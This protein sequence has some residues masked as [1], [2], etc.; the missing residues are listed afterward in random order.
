MKIG[1]IGVGAMG[2]PIAKLL[3]G[4]G[5][6]IVIAKHSNNQVALERI[7]D[8]ESTGATILN[9]I[10]DIPL[11]SDIIISILPG[12]KEIKSVY[13]DD[14]FSENVK[15][16]TTIIDMTS[17]S[18]DTII[19]ISNYY[20]PMDCHVIDAPVSGG[21][22]KAERGK[23]TI[24]GSGD[25][26]IFN[27]IRDIFEVIGDEIFY[28]GDIGNGKTIKTINQMMVAINLLGLVEA[29]SVMKVTGLNPDTVYDVIKLC[30]G[31]SYIFEKYFHRILSS[32]FEPG[33]K[34]RLMMKDL[35]TA[36]DI[37]S[38]LKLPISSKVYDLMSLLTD[39]YEKDIAVV[40]KLSSQ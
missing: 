34:L 6:T 23:L 4:A 15:R 20:S 18:P 1:F 38:E 29:L 8:L 3:I 37:D 12:D 14:E 21:V 36:M 24:F 26:D 2:H 17:C 39:D 10:N 11:H 25:K 7:A 19:E 31:N 28:V 22:S 16:G 30:S 40:S 13:L 35:K 5:Y 27:S 33:F 9:S 32:D